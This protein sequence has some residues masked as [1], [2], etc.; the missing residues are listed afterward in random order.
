MALW[1]EGVTALVIALFIFAGSFFQLR[2]DHLGGDALSVRFGALLQGL[3]FGGV[4]AFVMLPLRLQLM[5]GAMSGHGP[6]LPANGYNAWF[7]AL[8]LIW[9]IRSGVVARAPVI[10][11]PFRAYRLASLRRSVEIAQGRISRLEA[12]DAPKRGASA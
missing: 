12:L 3:L 2:D 4:V 1:I 11:H 9:V 10:G 5:Q 8:A 6:S 7:G